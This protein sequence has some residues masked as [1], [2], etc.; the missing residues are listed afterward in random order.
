MTRCKMCFGELE[1]L[2]D[3]G[4]CVECIEERRV[5]RCYRFGRR[6]H[7][8]GITHKGMPSVKG[9]KLNSANAVIGR[10][11]INDAVQHELDRLAQ[12]GSVKVIW[13]DGKKV[14]G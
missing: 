10:Y 12:H 14:D 7:S 2:S 5:T 3:N 13:K 11:V 8:E 6:V 9:Q 4:L 1:E